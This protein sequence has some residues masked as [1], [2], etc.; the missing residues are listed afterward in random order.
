[1]SEQEDRYRRCSRWSEVPRG[2]R[3]A[4]MVVAGVV[5]V[6]AFFALFGAVTMWLWNWLMPTIFKLPTI[7]FWQAVGI[8]ALSHILFKGNRFGKPGKRQWKKEKIR[9]RMGQ[10]GPEETAG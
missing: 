9:E 3:I 8:L 4:L 2:A 5:L 6:P 10:E 7:G 1:M